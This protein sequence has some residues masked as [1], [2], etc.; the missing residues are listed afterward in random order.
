MEM[1]D[2]CPQC[3]RSVKVR[4]VSSCPHSHV[5]STGLARA[6]VL[7]QQT[8]MA[9]PRLREPAS[10]EGTGGRHC[11][12]DVPLPQLVLAIPSGGSGGL[13]CWMLHVSV[14]G[15]AAARPP[16]SSARRAWVPRRPDH[17]PK[18]SGCEDGYED[19]DDHRVGEG[20]C[21]WSSNLWLVDHTPRL[22]PPWDAAPQVCRRREPG[23]MTRGLQVSGCH[24]R[25][26]VSRHPAM[27]RASTWVGRPRGRKPPPE[28]L[29]RT[30]GSP[31]NTGVL[32]PPSRAGRPRPGWR[33]HRPR[34]TDLAHPSSQ[35]PLTH[36]VGTGYSG[37][38]QLSR[39]E[40][41]R[42]RRRYVGNLPRPRAHRSP[43]PNLR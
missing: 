23:S 40:P 22:R 3:L 21:H 41:M 39:S 43:P 9:R 5:P 34:A 19:G 38:G 27:P 15:S 17:D 32:G 11:A 2:R 24:R 4:S 37:R 25:Q 6:R 28:V 35:V 1:P 18:S 31:C 8:V 29:H 30:P 12:I 14:L 10:I 26:R 16:K 42:M 13:P 33:Q 36:E 7:R 20:N